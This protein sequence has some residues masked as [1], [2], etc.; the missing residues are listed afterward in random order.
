[1]LSLEPRVGETSTTTGASDLT[2]S[3][4]ALPTCRTF[5]SAVGQNVPFIYAI[6]PV[7]TN[8]APTGTAYEIGVGYLSAATTLVRAFVL[9][10]SNSNAAVSLAAGTKNIYL[11]DARAWLDN[12]QDDFLY[13]SLVGSSDLAASL[14]VVGWGITANNDGTYTFQDGI[15]EHPGVLRLATNAASG[16]FVSLYRGNTPTAGSMLTP[17]N[18][19]VASAVVRIPTITSVAALFGL[20]QDASASTF[21]TA[22]A[23]VSFDPALSANFQTVT[24]QGG[25]ETRN[26]ST[27]A[28]AANTWYRIDI[29]HRGSSI[30]F[31]ANGVLLG[32]HSANL[33]TTACQPAFRV[34]TSTGASRT[35]DV[36][37]YADWFK[38]LARG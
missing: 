29:V 28:V 19:L 27:L 25:V 23:F 22:G 26:S 3:G 32:T 7:D 5:N 20:A 24:R 36:D 13:G 35:L 21:G 12:E 38:P 14:G 1:M 15:S 17:G 37:Y 10:S 16:S 33:P 9:R 2:L 4:V 11:V 6:E 34:A 18:V 31:F 8:G 30:S